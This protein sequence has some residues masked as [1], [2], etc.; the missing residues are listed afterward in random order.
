VPEADDVGA[1]G[2]ITGRRSLFKMAG[3]VATPWMVLCTT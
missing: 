1:A 3:A 2:R